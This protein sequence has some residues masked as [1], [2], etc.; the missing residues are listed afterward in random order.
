MLM[1]LPFTSI[2]FN[3]SAFAK[4]IFRTNLSITAKYDINITR[5]G[6]ECQLKTLKCRKLY[7]YER[8]FLLKS[9]S[10]SNVP[11]Y[12]LNHTNHVYTVH[13]LGINDTHQCC[14]ADNLLTSI[15][16][17][18]S[19]KLFVTIYLHKMHD[20]FMQAEFIHAVHSI[21][22]EISTSR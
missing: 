13:Y 12:L 7:T 22:A 11:H 5:Y 6:I 18:H 8:T 19:L 9:D 1:F 4:V 10:K 3:H 17:L 14:S 21:G 2:P 20:L 15:N 16:A